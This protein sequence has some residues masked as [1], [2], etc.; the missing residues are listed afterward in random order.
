MTAFYNGTSM[1]ELE[2]PDCG[3]KKNLKAKYMSETGEMWVHCDKCGRAGNPG[4]TP[5]EAIDGWT[6]KKLRV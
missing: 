5:Q 3:E 4:F 1:V 6:N 2:C